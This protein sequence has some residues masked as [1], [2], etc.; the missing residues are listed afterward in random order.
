MRQIVTLCVGGTPFDLTNKV[1]AGWLM[2]TMNAWNG[3]HSIPVHH[4]DYH[5]FMFVTPWGRY[6]YKMAPQGWL[7]SGDAYTHC[8]D[9]ITSNIDRHIKVTDDSL[10]WSNDMQQAWADITFSALLEARV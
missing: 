9:Q 6:R 4:D 1:T 10:I 8:Y 3:F 5:Y 2:S 7:A